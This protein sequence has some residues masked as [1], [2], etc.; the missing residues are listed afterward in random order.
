MSNAKQTTVNPAVNQPGVNQPAVVQVAG[1]RGS[2]HLKVGTIGFAASNFQVGPLQVGQTQT[3]MK[4]LIVGR[5][6]SVVCDDCVL[7]R[8]VSRPGSV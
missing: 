7:C 4:P 6:G 2:P 8:S 3:K 1:F 5:P